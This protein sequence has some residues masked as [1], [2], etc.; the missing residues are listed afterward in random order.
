VGGEAVDEGF[1]FVVEG[2]G[3]LV[4]VLEGIDEF[5]VRRG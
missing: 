4:L 2:F 1:E 3:L 5:A